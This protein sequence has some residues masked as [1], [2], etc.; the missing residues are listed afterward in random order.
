MCLRN[1]VMSNYS[2]LESL[3]TPERNLAPVVH[4]SVIKRTTEMKKVDI[5][6]KGEKGE[7]PGFYTEPIFKLRKHDFF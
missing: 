4:I 3:P 1:A 6:K 7:M 5:P 2:L